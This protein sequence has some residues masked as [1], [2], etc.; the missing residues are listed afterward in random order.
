MAQ[1]QNVID[2][3]TEGISPCALCVSDTEMRAAIAYISWVLNN[4]GQEGFDVGDVME[5]AA[6]LACESDKEMLAHIL[7]IMATFVISKGYGNDVATLL[8]NSACLACAPPRMVRAI[9]LKQ[10]CTMMNALARP[11]LL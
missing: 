8:K 11:I 9:I 5:D 7:G 2:C 10:F 3:T 6:C 1:V 4:A